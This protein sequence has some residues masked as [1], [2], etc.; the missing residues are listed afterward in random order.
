MVLHKAAL[1]QEA[2]SPVGRAVDQFIEKVCTMGVEK[3][4]VMYL[5]FE[6]LCNDS[7]QDDPDRK[8]ASRLIPSLVD[9]CFTGVLHKKGERLWLE[10]CAYV[11]SLGDSCS[12]N[13]IMSSMS[14]NDLFT[15]III[16]N[17]LSTLQ[18]DV[19]ADHCFVM[20]FLYALRVKYLDLAALTTFK[21]FSNSL[22]H[23]QKHRMVLVFLLLA[24][25]IQED[26]SGEFLSKLWHALEIECHPSVRQNLEWLIILLIVRFPQ[27]LASIWDVFKLYDDKRSVCLCSLFLIISIIGPKLPKHLQSQ[28]YSQAL[29]AVLP[30]TM[31]HHYNTRIFAQTTLTCLW[32]QVQ[33]CDQL[34]TSQY[35]MIQG[36]VE[37][38]FKNGNASATVTKLLTNFMYSGFDPVRDYSMESIFH[39]MPRLAC[40]ADDEW[41]LPRQFVQLDSKWQDDSN[42]LIKLRNPSCE[43]ALCKE[44]P[45]RT[46][47]QAEN[48]DDIV[49]SADGDVQ[50]KI[51]PWRQMSPDQETESELTSQ[52]QKKSDEG[53]ILVTSL[54][55]KIPN[56]GGLC[57]TSEIFGVSEFVISNLTHVE[58]RMFQNLS[59]SAQKWI[60]IT[61]VMR[62]R[63]PEFLEEKR[64]QGY[65]LV[66]VEQTAN[67]VCL[68]EYQFPKKTLLLLGNEREGI[69]V[70]IIQS[71]DVCVEIPQQGVIRSLNV[72]VCGA[73]IVWEYTRQHM[74]QSK[75]STASTIK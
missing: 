73:L 66:G 34:V 37:F 61:E 47:A 70:D 1:E 40:L 16:L 32:K 67:S 46:K 39:T 31:A 38:I 21:Q 56:L 71:L 5:L 55:D 64:L 36:A 74:N 4:G 59:V 72:H 51:M 26:S 53:L 62:P 9:G 52:R 23:R 24:D 30:W 6:H 28:Y 27:N 10:V 2:G 48:E 18:P 15:R 43:L 12:V 19:P 20:K 63:I 7:L 45:W 3:S 58:D 41:I 49:E 65:T 11:E 13:Q 14:K 25:F 8:R 57:R 29:V 17:W 50:K 60:T 75:N 54:V 35:A 33:T 69:P 68:Q 42:N 44:G 22:S